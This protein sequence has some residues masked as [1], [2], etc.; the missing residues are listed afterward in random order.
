MLTTKERQEIER[1]APLDTARLMVA[2]VALLLLTIGVIYGGGK[3]ICY[4]CGS[5]YDKNDFSDCPWCNTQLR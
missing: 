1:L 5:F 4:S 3:A 2:T